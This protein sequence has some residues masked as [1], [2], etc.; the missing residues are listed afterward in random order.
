MLSMRW[1]IALFFKKKDPSRCTFKKKKSLRMAKK[2]IQS[3]SDAMC[4]RSLS[5]WKL[6]RS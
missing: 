4:L 1:A 6:R 5:D 2:L 3:Q